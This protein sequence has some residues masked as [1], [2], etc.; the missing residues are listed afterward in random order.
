MEKAA[1]CFIP[2]LARASMERPRRAARGMRHS[3]GHCNSDT[4]NPMFQV[5]RLDWE[6]G[7]FF[8]C[9][10]TGVGPS[11]ANLGLS[12]CDYISTYLPRSPVGGM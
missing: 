7:F 11:S 5:G 8:S 6:S 1:P 4:Q 10:T 3:D 9:A 2:N 12:R